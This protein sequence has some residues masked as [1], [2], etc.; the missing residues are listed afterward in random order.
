MHHIFFS[1]SFIDGHLG[2]FHAVAI[3][4][5]AAVNTEGH[6]SF[7]IMIF[8]RYMPSSGFVIFNSNIISSYKTMVAQS[9]KNLPAMRETWVHSLGWEDLLDKSMATHSS[10][11][12]WSIPWTGE[13]GYS[14]WDDWATNTF[15][16]KSK[17]KIC[18]C[19]VAKSCSTLSN[20]MNCS[21]PGFPLF[22][23]HP[24]F[25]QTHIH[26]ASDGIQPSHP[27]SSLLLPPSIFPSIRVFSN[28]SALCIRWPEYWSFSFSISPSNEYSGLISFRVDW[29]DLLAVQGTLKSLLQHHCSKASIFCA[30]LSL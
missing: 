20:P 24:E 30:Q 21:T 29:L 2:F 7:W 4:N 10:P 9:V 6:V 8:F 25:A 13:P 17:L 3:V 14:P 15:T 23:C 11:L 16:F 5:S 19:S 26:W 12:A 28:E 1:Y 22:Y 18:C 27:L